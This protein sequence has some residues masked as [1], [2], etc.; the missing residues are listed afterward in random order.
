MAARSTSF[1]DTFKGNPLRP[2]HGQISK[3]KKHYWDS[4]TKTWKKY[5]PPAK[6]VASKDANKFFGTNDYGSGGTKEVKKKN[7]KNENKKDNK[8]G[9][10]LKSGGITVHLKGGGT[11]TY[12]PGHEDYEAIKSSK[13]APSKTHSDAVKT[14]MLGG[15]VTSKKTNSGDTNTKTSKTKPKFSSNVHT[16][17]YK[18]GE[19]LGVMG[20]SQR[21]RYEKE[22]AGRTF[23]GEVAKHE[24][25][26]GHGKSHLRETLYKRSHSSTNKKKAKIEKPKTE[27]KKNKL[28]ITEQHA[29][30]AAQKQN[31][32]AKV[33][34][35]DPRY[36]G[37]KYKKKKNG[38]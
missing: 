3:D 31:E 23:K 17:H 11:K 10:K 9:N 2:K 12:Y 24:K 1:S 35:N 26:S 16:R 14:S 32:T 33:M 21:L 20:R 30:K 22:A 36:K 28:T 8:N 4:K 34:Q 29:S 27:P 7:K 13:K 5:L 18:T 37:P 19:R 25:S 6:K 38:G 15:K